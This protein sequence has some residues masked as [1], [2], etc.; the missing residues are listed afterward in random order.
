MPAKR[1][2]ASPGERFNS[3]TV[4]RQIPPPGRA[5]VECLCDCG[6]VKIVSLYDLRSGTTKSCGCYARKRMANLNRTHGLSRTHPL[7]STWSAMKDRCHNTRSPSYPR[8]GGRGIQV[9][10][11][12][13]KS[14]VSFIA[15]VG[16]RPEGGYT[17]DRINND[18]NYEPGNVR[19]ATWT[20]QVA[21]RRPAKK[22]MPRVYCQKGLHLFEETMIVKPNGVRLCGECSREYLRLY[23]ENLRAKKRLG[24]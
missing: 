17:L 19:W 12:W 18:G 3:Y 13:R 16:D 23:R 8:Y 9:C 20:Q 22:R 14:F 15:H 1:V 11:E 4:I 6:T 10:D 24:G 2:V 21:N 7:F 5:R